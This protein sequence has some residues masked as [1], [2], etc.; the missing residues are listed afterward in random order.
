[1]QTYWD[2]EEIERAA[3]S[4][5]DVEGFLDTELMTAGVL[6]VEKPT[7][8]PV[9]EIEIATR[10]VYVV[11]MNYTNT[12]GFDTLEQTQQFL[13]LQ[14]MLIERG[15]LIGGRYT[16]RAE[17]IEIKVEDLSDEST[18]NAVKDVL[19][20]SR[21]AIDTNEKSQKE[22]KKAKTKDDIVSSTIHEDWMSCREK[23]EKMKK[24]RSTLAE[25]DVLTDDRCISMRF[26][27]RAFSRK[28][29]IEASKWLGEE[30]AI[31]DAE[32]AEAATT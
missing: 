5:K 6:R 23:D 32:Q 25:Y 30:W 26:L 28:D 3:L 9:Q 2:L 27:L 14:P 16:S 4:Q 24:V 29:V 18:V 19:R 20:E 13:G 12:L 10:N 15:A 21:M 11:E 31:P 8:E 7:L 17:R 1:M 22:Y